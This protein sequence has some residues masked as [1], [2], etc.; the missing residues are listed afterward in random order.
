MQLLLLVCFVVFLL[1]LPVRLVLSLCCGVKLQPPGQA[2]TPGAANEDDFDEHD[3]DVVI[4]MPEETISAEE[5]VHLNR[6]LLPC[7]TVYATLLSCVAK[8]L[9]MARPKAY[10]GHNPLY[11]HACAAFS[12]HSATS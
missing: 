4:N 8:E 7:P 2:Q 12:I 5:V 1:C 10:K 11:G 6:S 9:V 3:R